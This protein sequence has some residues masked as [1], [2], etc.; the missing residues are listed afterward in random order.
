[1]KL[2][3]N[4]PEAPLSRHSGANCTHK[5]W[6]AALSHVG[7]TQLRKPTVWGMLCDLRKIT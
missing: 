5:E 4:F 7:G 2:H 1:M 6:E 3:L